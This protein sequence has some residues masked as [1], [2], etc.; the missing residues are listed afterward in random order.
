M[1]KNEF[2]KN[3]DNHKTY[4]AYMFYGVS[5]YLVE[6]YSLKV[7]LS[8]ANADSITKVY[9]DD[10]DFE[11]CYDSLTQNSLFSS[12]NIL[13]IKI[14][15]KLPKKDIDKLIEACNIN[16]H[17][18]VIFACI[19][20]VDFKSMAKSFSVKTSSVEVRFFQPYDNEAISILSKQAKILNLKI[21]N[22]SLGFLYNIHQK[23]LALCIS[24]LTKL[25]ILREPISSKTINTH[26]FGLGTIN[27]EDLLIDLFNGVNI[28]KNLYFLLEEGVTEIYLL[29]RIT[30]FVQNLFMINAY[31]KL[32]GNLNIKEIWGYPL[33]QQ[34]A[35]QQAQIATKYKQE[36]YI[37]ML[38]F[39]QDFELE[40][41]SNKIPDINAYFQAKLR[42]FL[43]L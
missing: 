42:I 37:Y 18:K 29:G 11:N 1:Y 30:A 9:F 12:T 31:L 27:I 43:K 22:S 35:Q 34:V 40:L 38:N 26:C 4:S 36:D 19:G 14:S 2:D 5:D 28:N 7:A 16:T 24:D 17:S 13:L 33:P 10:Y 25:S 23:N 8:L 32:H 21:E 3:F 15:K 39:L 6:N 41:K 20:D